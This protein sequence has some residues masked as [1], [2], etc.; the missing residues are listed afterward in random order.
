MP[1][2]LAEGGSV[3]LQRYT[4]ERELGRGGMA[5][6]H[7]ARDERLHRPVAVKL[8]DPTVGAALGPERFL[9]E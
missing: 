2:R 7:L 8:L 3:L 5:T 1:D 6:V 4:L 9:R